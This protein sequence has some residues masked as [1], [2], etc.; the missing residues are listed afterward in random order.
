MT[1][2]TIPSTVIADKACSIR[3]KSS[4]IIP[5]IRKTLKIYVQNSHIPAWTGS[6][7][8]GLTTGQSVEAGHE[9]Y[10]KTAEQMKEA[11]LAHSI[12]GYDKNDSRY[13]FEGLIARLILSL[14]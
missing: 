5:R 2:R 11:N 9:T 7:G 4:S 1:P 10:P 8:T 6:S 14:N 3:R 12:S 13:R